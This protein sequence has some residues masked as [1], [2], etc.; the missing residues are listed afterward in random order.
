MEFSCSHTRYLAVVGVCPATAEV[1]QGDICV[2]LLSIWLA[3]AKVAW[4]ISPLSIADLALLAAH[5]A[6]NIALCPSSI[7]AAICCSSS[8]KRLPLMPIMV[9]SDSISRLTTSTTPFCLGKDCG[10][11]IAGIW[12][13]YAG[14]PRRLGV[15]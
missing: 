6:T 11:I 3:V 4:V 8:A 5:S 1:L 10:K 13:D 15:F 14:L 12:G 7:L 2:S 9:I